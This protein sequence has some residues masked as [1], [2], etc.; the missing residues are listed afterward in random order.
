MTAVL[1]YR[2]VNVGAQDVLLKDILSPVIVRQ[3]ALIAGQSHG[4]SWGFMPLAMS[5]R[6]S[7]DTIAH[8]T[9]IAHIPHCA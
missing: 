6:P 5:M 2:I 9:H 3:K 7:F 8:Y 1:C 4:A